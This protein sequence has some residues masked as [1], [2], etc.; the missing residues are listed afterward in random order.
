MF[1]LKLIAGGAL[2]ILG[3]KLFWLFVA[4]VGF[5]AAI[6]LA[7]RYLH[8]QPEWVTVLLA[9]GAGLIGALLATFFQSLAIWLAGFIGGGLFA[10][11][12][13]ALFGLD[14][15]SLDWIIFL[16][17]GITSGVLIAIFFDWALMILSSLGGASLINGLLHFN[18]P[19][20]I[21]AFIVL[22]ILGVSIQ[23]RLRRAERMR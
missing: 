4:G 8:G 22:F 9:L 14:K 18:Q 1:I 20:S 17:G 5:F 23:V 11:S 12:T 3:R 15:G 21:L 19:F 2:L 10:A 6:E 16:I 7:G 13:L